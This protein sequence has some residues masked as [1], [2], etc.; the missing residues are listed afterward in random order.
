MADYSKQFDEAFDFGMSDFD[1]QEIFDTLE[2]N[3]YQSQICEGLGTYAVLKTEE[4]EMLLA[5]DSIEDSDK[6]EWVTL[7]TAIERAGKSNN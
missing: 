6:A 3:H 2:P 4:G 7:E 5:V 1:Y